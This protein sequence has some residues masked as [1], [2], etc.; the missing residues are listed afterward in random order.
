MSVPAP[1]YPPGSL[2][3][4]LVQA[5][6]PLAVSSGASTG[7]VTFSV[8]FPD[9]DYQVAI[10]WVSGAPPTQGIGIRSKTV[11]NYI[12]AWFG[13]VGDGAFVWNAWRL[14]RPS[15]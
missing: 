12:A 1:R 14:W 10:E 8:A 6:G 9:T 4:T 3:P 15:S 7:A 2:S 11:D 13:T 5:G